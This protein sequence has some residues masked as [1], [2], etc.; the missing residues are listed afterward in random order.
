MNPERDLP[1]LDVSRETLRRLRTLEALVRKWSPAI[2]LV[3]RGSLDEIW[4]R[5]VRD[6]AQLW[7]LRPPAPR[8]WVDLGAGAGFPGLVVAIL[9]TEAAPGLEVRLIESDAR[10]AVFLREAARETGTD[11]AI[12][13]ERIETVA[14]QEADVVS[15]RALAPLPTL[16]RHLER[17]ARPGGIGLFPKGETVH[18]EIEE[19]QKIWSFRFELHPSQSR[20]GAAIVEVGALSRV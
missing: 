18:K 5:H 13:C 7:R 12:L 20:A 2:N 6:S 10:K 8:R 15:A 4:D 14:P 17:H 16:L 9:A 3:S 19:A 11:V 1:D